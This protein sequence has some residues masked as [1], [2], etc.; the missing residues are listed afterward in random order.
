MCCRAPLYLTDSIPLFLHA[1]S[2][3]F[4]FPPL[5]GD[6]WKGHQQAPLPVPSVGF[7]QWGAPARDGV[8]RARS[9]CFSLKFFYPYVVS[10]DT[11]SV[12]RVPK[13]LHDFVCFHV[14]GPTF[15]FHP[16]VPKYPD[17]STAI[18]SGSCTVP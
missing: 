15:S 3:I 17:R 13:V 16:S 1:P 6:L 8:R 14:L 5:G 10:C 11:D 7:G 9:G 2:L 12:P 4:S 18:S